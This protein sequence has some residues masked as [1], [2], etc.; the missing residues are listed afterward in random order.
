M[1]YLDPDKGRLRE[2]ISQTAADANFRGLYNRAGLTRLWD[3]IMDVHA[4][5]GGN[6]VGN[7]IDIVFAHSD[8]IPTYPGYSVRSD[9]AIAVYRNLMQD[10]LNP[11][12]GEDGTRVGGAGALPPYGGEGTLWTTFDPKEEGQP[13]TDM[14]CSVAGTAASAQDSTLP[15]WRMATGAAD[16][17]IA[18]YFDGSTANPRAL[19]NRDKVTDVIARFRR[20]SG[21]GT[22]RAD[23][24]T[25]GLAAVAIS[26]G[27]GT[28]VCNGATVQ[29]MKWTVAGHLGLDGDAPNTIQ[30]GSPAGGSGANDHF[31]IV[32]C[33]RDRYRGIRVHNL[34]NPGSRQA[35]FYGT[36]N[37]TPTTFGTALVDNWTANAGTGLC[38]NAKAYFADFCL[39]DETANSETETVELFEGQLR[40][41]TDRL[42]AAPSAPML[43]YFIPPPGGNAER[44]AIHHLYVKAIKRVMYDN[45]DMMTVWD[46]GEH[47]GEGV[48]GE[49]AG[50]SYAAG[51]APYSNNDLSHLSPKGQYALG[52]KLFAASVAGVLL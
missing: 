38:D 12:M 43:F 34:A 27:A 42:R 5:R 23:V 22:I 44:I 37:T 39:N 26:G 40:D 14:T 36:G 25:D 24:K 8:S 13:R 31:G 47:W 10:H 41:F 49:R 16:R 51:F 11:I 20:F 52:H 3:Y 35:L 19:Q 46:L 18:Y 2:G 33:Y 45:L 1:A 21:D 48:D 17:T 28:I 50:S 30:Y 7:G 32:A 9:T 15:F 4:D 6:S 29:D